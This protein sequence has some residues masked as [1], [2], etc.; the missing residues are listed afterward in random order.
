[1]AALGNVDMRRADHRRG[2]IKSLDALDRRNLRVTGAARPGIDGGRL[3][4]GVDR[5]LSEAEL[6]AVRVWPSPGQQARELIPGLATLG[7]A[8]DHDVIDRPAFKAAAPSPDID[9]D[10]VLLHIGAGGQEQAATRNTADL[11]R[12]TALIESLPVRRL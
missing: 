12:F 8:L 2:A 10:T 9:L 11:P 4:A 7:A 1:L 5:E 6:R 3:V